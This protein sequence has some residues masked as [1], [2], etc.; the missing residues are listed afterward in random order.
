MALREFADFL[1]GCVEAIPHVKG[2]AIL[3]DCEQNHKLLKKLPDWIMRRW[4]RIVVGELDESGDY[5]SFACFTEFMQKEARIACNPIAS[6]L[7]MNIKATDERLPKRVKVLNTSIQGKISSSRSLD[8][9]KSKPPCLV[10]KDET[11]GVAKCP[12]F[13]KKTADEKKAFIHENQICFGCLRKGHITKDCKRRHICS[14][15]GKRHP[16]CLHIERPAERVSENSVATENNT[17]K[18]REISKVMTHAL[19]QHTSATSSI[20]PVLVSSKLKPQREILTYALL[21]TQSDSTFI[22][23]DIVT[24]LNVN[25]QSVQLKLSTMTAVNTVIA[26]EIVNGLQVRGLNSEFSVQ[27][28]QAYT[29]DFIPIDKSHI[30]TKVTALQWPHLQHLSTKL[31]PLQDCEVGL[32]IGCDCPSVLAPLEVIMGDENEPFAQRTVLGWSII[33][34]TNPHLDRQG[35]QNFVHRVAVKEIPVPSTTDV[36]KVLESDFNEKSYEDKHVSQEDVRFLQFLSDNIKHKEDGHYM[37]PLPFKSSNPPSLPNNR[38]L[39]NVR[40]QHLKRKLETNEQYRNHYISFM[41]DIILKGH[42]E[43]APKV[44]EGEPVWYIPH[45]GVYHPRKPDKLRVVFDCSAKF[46]GISLND[47]LLTG[48]DLINPLVGVLCRFRKE[49]VAVTCD[50]ERMFHQFHVSPEVRNYLRF[51]WWEGGDLE[52][53]P[54][55]YRMTVHL[56]GAASSPGCANFSLKYL[57]QQHKVEQ[58][59]AS[60][61]EKNFY[62]DDGLTSVATVEEAKELIVN[63]QE[64]CKGAGLRL[65]K[66]SSNQMEALSCVAPSERAITTDPLTLHPDA[67]PD[68]HVL[69]IQWSMKNDTFSFNMI[70]K[71]HPQ[72]AEVSYQLSPPFTTHLG[73]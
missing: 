55:E 51:L 36:L 19:T 46:H 60:A 18:E 28:Q 63:T 35:N 41:E 3:N 43:P 8:S 32:L 12:T 26:S 69:G 65:H 59:A 64:L 29:R 7:L 6:P 4:S 72:L 49:A 34:S 71:D 31:P 27:L 62:V 2:L 30:P 9:S 47:T 15:C 21:D 24:E 20:V 16:T 11:H 13:A 45:H 66:F 33:G 52:A 10:C 1:Q 42:A 25:T 44:S 53:E 23:E 67:V 54:K 58:P 68:G 61:F 48:P 39:A 57:A 22:L 14:T 37:M 56:F 17:S 40:L 73:L 38:R 50:I 70:A 5:P